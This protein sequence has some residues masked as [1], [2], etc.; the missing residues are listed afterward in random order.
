[1]EVFSDI[2]LFFFNIFTHIIWLI[3]DFYLLFFDM[4]Y[5]VFLVSVTIMLLPVINISKFANGKMPSILNMLH[6][7]FLIY[8]FILSYF[9]LIVAGDDLIRHGE[10]MI[11]NH[12]KL[13]ISF[14]MYLVFCLISVSLRSQ[15]MIISKGIKEA[16]H[17]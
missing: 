17:E 12:E 4:K 13:Y 16:E 9:W 8:I 6:P 5:T 2:F 7:G 1:M 10:V 11:A 3:R 14:L 15:S